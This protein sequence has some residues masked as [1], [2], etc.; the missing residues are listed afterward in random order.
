VTKLSKWKTACDKHGVELLVVQAEG[1]RRI[2]QECPVCKAEQEAHEGHVIRR[3]A[4]ETLSCPIHGGE[5][6]VMVLGNVRYVEPCERCQKEQQA[7][8]AKKEKAQERNRLA[9]LNDPAWQVQQG[10]IPPA[11]VGTAPAE[12]G[13]L[14]T[15]ISIVGAGVPMAL[16]RGPRGTGKTRAAY[17]VARC[18]LRRKQSSVFWCVPQLLEA[19]RTDAITDQRAAHA[20]LGQ[21]V[22]TPSLVILDDL[23]AEKRSEFTTEQL[24]III[25]SR[26]DWRRPLLVTTE[27]KFADLTQMYGDRISSRLASGELVRFT[28]HDRRLKNAKE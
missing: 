3:L 6:Q 17:A 4:N 20:R 16:F 15:S 27:Y 7:A 28:G 11:F 18:Y 5:Q 14:A 23:G 8:Q 21:L 1:G 9:A 24:F 10:G 12:F 25:N 26:L 22:S 13:P 2:A 19:M